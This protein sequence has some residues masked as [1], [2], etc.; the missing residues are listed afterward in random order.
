MIQKY[1]TVFLKNTS[2]SHS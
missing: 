1:V 2:I